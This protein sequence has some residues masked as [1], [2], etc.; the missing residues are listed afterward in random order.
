[1]KN[2]P[3]ALSFQSDCGVTKRTVGIECL[4][5]INR[6]LRKKQFREPS[7]VGQKSIDGSAS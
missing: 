3:K 1:V 2:D 5:K 7:R 6:G 4:L